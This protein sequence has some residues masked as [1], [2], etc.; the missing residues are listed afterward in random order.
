LLLRPRFNLALTSSPL[1]ADV[2]W[3]GA[4]NL[5]LVLRLRGFLARSLAA[6]ESGTISS[7]C[8]ARHNCA[9]SQK[10][11]RVRSTHLCAASP[12]ASIR[13]NCRCFGILFENLSLFLC[14]L[15]QTKAV[16]RSPQQSYRLALPAVMHVASAAARLKKVRAR[17]TYPCAALS[18]ASIRLNRAVAINAG[19]L[20]VCSR[21]GAAAHPA[22]T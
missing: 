1:A 6:A 11:T 5:F 13:L 20:G 17:S 22:P 21:F 2:R 8:G 19:I 10:K 12:A 15:R 16:S 7:H 14:F 18:A 9:R 3:N 4:S